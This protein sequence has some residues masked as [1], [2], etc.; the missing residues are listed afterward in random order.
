MVILKK[1]L[2]IFGGFYDNLRFVVHVIIFQV[3]RVVSCIYSGLCRN[4]RYFN[5]TYLFNLETNQWEE[6]K[7]SSSGL[8]E[9]PSQRSACQMGVCNKTN[10]I[11]V[12]GGFSK[13]K[14]KQDTEKG[15][16]H[17]DMF[18]LSYEGKY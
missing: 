5:D 17:T 3:V 4:C 9:G 11:L 8:S 7:F 6:M 10:T 13:A 1:Y 14:G 12:Y 16:V 18:T 15:V 2:V